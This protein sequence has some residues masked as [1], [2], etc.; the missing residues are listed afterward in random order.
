MHET[1]NQQVRWAQ[2]F[3]RRVHE[4]TGSD[5]LTME[6]LGGFTIYLFP[7]VIGLRMRW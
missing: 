4:P 6:E 1:A 2:G 7:E 3:E 5:R